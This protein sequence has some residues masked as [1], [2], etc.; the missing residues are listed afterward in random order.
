MRLLVERGGASNGSVPNGATAAKPTAAASRRDLR[1]RVLVCLHGVAA[2]LLVAMVLRR[3]M[4]GTVQHAAPAARGAARPAARECP[5]FG[6]SVLDMPD[7]ADCRR[8]M[9]LVAP[10]MPHR[11]QAM[12]GAAPS[13][14]CCQPAAAFFDSQCH[15]WSSQFGAEALAGIG[16]VDDA[17]QARLLGCAWLGW[18]CGCLQRSRCVAARCGRAEVCLASQGCRQLTQHIDGCT[19]MLPPIAAGCQRQQRQQRQRHKRQRE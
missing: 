19:A 2:L 6:G 12:V 15:C 3:S 16:A 7:T 10:C 11:G 4:H 18:S 8:L 13:A 1:S 9:A 17:C 5:H 14:A